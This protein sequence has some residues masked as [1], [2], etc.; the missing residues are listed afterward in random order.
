MMPWAP[1]SAKGGYGPHLRK[2]RMCPLERK[3]GMLRGPDPPFALK[4]AHAGFASV[5]ARYPRSRSRGDVAPAD[6][7]LA[8]HSQVKA[9]GDA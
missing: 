9:K 2:P 1:L 6:A 5:G 8:S 4:E 7:N 3:G